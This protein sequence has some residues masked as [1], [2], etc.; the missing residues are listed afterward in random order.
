MFAKREF[1]FLGFVVFFSLTARFAF[2]D[3]PFDPKRYAFELFPEDE[4]ALSKY[5]AETGE[6]TVALML[7][8]AWGELDKAADRAGVLPPEKAKAAIREAVRGPGGVSDRFEK[9]LQQAASTRAGDQ[10]KMS[11]LKRAA[12][13]P[14]IW[15][16]AAFFLAGFYF[17]NRRK[18]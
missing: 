7:E 14:L 5:G 11:R 15:L 4:M 13:H 1:F 8:R 18:S 9:D 16:L 17:L 12:R 3:Q 10:S 2:A 6:E